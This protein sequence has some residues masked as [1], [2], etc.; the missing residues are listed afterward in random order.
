MLRSSKELDRYVI[1]VGY[2]Q[3]GK[4]FTKETLDYLKKIDNRKIAQGLAQHRQWWKN[5][6]MASTL[7]LPDPIYQGFYDMQLYKLA[8]ATRSDKPAMDLQGPWTSPT[9]GQLIGST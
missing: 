2:S 9:P 4:D 8:S 1:T 5:Y 3:E 6:F 7:E